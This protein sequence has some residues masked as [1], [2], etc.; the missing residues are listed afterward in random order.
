MKKICR[1]FPDYEVNA[2]GEIFSRRG[3]LVGQLDW[4]G[5]H[6]VHLRRDGK[7][8]SVAVHRLVAK[9]FV[10][11]P[12]NKPQVNHKNGVKND[13][14]AENLEWCTGSENQLHRAHVLKKGGWAKL[15]KERVF[16]AKSLV[17][18]GVKQSVVAK[19]FGV[20]QSTIS[21]AVRGKTWGA[22]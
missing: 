16:C 20:K 15:T 18:A 13:N 22:L 8:H 9:E 21:Y 7:G 11:N 2:E 19:L 6:R 5:Y 3:K 1:D 10:D 17:G 4:K 12:E 14:R